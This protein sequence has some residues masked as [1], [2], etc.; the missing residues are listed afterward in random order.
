MPAQSI[1]AIVNPLLTLDPDT[2]DNSDL[3]ILRDLVGE[4][5]VVCLGESAH[6]ASEFVR[7]RDRIARYLVRELGF[8]AFVLESGLPEGLAVDEWVRGGPGS[9]ATI[10]RRGITYAFGRCEEMHAQLQ[11]M[12]DWNATHSHQVGFYGMDVPGWCANPAAGVAACL[13]RLSPQ[14]GDR[15]LLAAADLGDPTRAASADGP[16]TP[17]VPAELSRGVTELVARATAADD[18]IALRCA[19]GAQ[20]VV[21]FLQHGLYPE[22]RRNL[23]NEVM[24]DN[25]HWIL[26]REERVIVGAHNV[27]LQRTPTFDGTEPIG[28]LLAPVLGQELVVIGTTRGAGI[29]PGVDLDATPARRY[30][31]PAGEFSAPSHSLDALLDAVGLPQHLVDLRHAPPELLAGA[32]AMSGQTQL[33][34]L[35]PKQAFDA[36]VHIHQITPAH[37]ATDRRTARLAPPGSGQ[38]TGC[39][40]NA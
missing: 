26:G 36:V 6:F 7:L 12:R 9:L 31:T 37:G 30:T 16:D 14:P 35:D 5:R 20:R 21:D 11:W 40:A 3:E 10:A 27:H 22:P 28:S 18:E 39:S 13:D 38:R 29:V 17:D 25:L 24:A 8:S 33:I 19:H 1:R 23:R 32:T 2:S 34:D 4:A 15:E